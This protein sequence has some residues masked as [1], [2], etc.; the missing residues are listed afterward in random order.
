MEDSDQLIQTRLVELLGLERWSVGVNTFRTPSGVVAVWVDHL[1]TFLGWPSFDPCWHLAG[2]CATR[3][4]PAGRGQAR[5][6]VRVAWVP[7]TDTLTVGGRV[8]SLGV[9]A[10]VPTDS[11]IEALN[12][13]RLFGPSPS[14]SA[15]DGI[16]YWV[17][18]NSGDVAGNFRLSNPHRPDLVAVECSAF[19][20]GRQLGDATGSAALKEC[21]DIWKRYEPRVDVDGRAD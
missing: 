12:S 20:L 18:F 19:A 9:A 5:T 17:W 4:G 8:T 10:D 15:L 13:M 21:L 6:L 16:G 3:E 11:F 1:W 14:S 7:E 2:V